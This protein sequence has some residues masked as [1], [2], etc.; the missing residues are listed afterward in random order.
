MHL[1]QE[2]LNFERME[3]LG[4]AFVMAPVIRRLYHTKEE[5]AM[6]LKRHLE[7]FNTQVTVCSVVFGLT[8]A[9]EEQGGNEADRA[10]AGMKAGLMGPLAGIGD[11]L[12]WSTWQPICLSLGAALALNGNFL[13]PILAWVLFNIVQVSAK[14]YG[15]MAGY[16]QG[17]AL[18]SRL[19][20]QFE[21]VTTLASI[22]GLMVIGS[23]VPSLVGVTTPAVVKVGDLTIGIQQILD[24]IMPNIL[25]LGFTLFA[26]WLIRRKWSPLNIVLLLIAISLV[27]TAFN[28]L[29]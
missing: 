16:H 1:F 11:S 12:I 7:F 29:A 13:G 6:A 8:A 10:I 15:V 5:R 24:S 22:V 28:W 20:G 27:L 3:A 17:I 9:M 23:L 25:P 4:Y 18:L 2:S 19:K 26:F 21:V 14:Y